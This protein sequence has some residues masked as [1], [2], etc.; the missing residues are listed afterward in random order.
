MDHESDIRFIYA[1]TKSNGCDYD[2]YAVVHPLVL[3]VLFVLIVDV[4]VVECSS[5]ASLVE[6]AAH[7]L[8][9]LLREA[10]DDAALPNALFGER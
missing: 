10:V 7:L 8:A 2:V 9:L 6:S 4:C 1:H 3:D 5:V